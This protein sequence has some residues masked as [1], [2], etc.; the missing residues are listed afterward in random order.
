MHVM[1]TQLTTWAFSCPVTFCLCLFSK[2][3]TLSCLSYQ[4]LDPSRAGATSGIMFTIKIM[5]K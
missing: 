5:A 1:N 3:F 2:L 4:T